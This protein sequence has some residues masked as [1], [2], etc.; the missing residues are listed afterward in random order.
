LRA[1]AQRVGV[2]VTDVTETLPAGS[3]YLSWQRST[4]DHLAAALQTAAR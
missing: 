1:E 4:V 2:P 3:D